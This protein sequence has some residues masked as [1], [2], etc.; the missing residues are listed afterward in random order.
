MKRLNINGT[1]VV[2]HYLPSKLT[3][4]KILTNVGSCVEPKEIWGIAHILEHMFF[5]GS[6]KRPGPLQIHAEA[7]NI[8][9]KLNAATS[10]DYTSYHITVLNEFFREGFDILADMY[11]NPI[12]PADEFTKEINPILSELRQVQDSPDTFL[13]N[14]VLNNMLGEEHYHPIIGTEKTVKSATLEYV[15]RFR[16]KYY[17]GNNVLISIVGGLDEQQVIDVVSEL[18]VAPTATDVACIK[19][20]TYNGGEVSLTKEGITEA[21]YTLT[22]PALD[23]RHPDRVKQAVMSYV[24]GGSE[25][26]MLFER[27]REELGMSCYGIYSSIHRSDPFNLLEVSCGIEPTQV[28]DLHKE[29]INQIE[30]ISS[31]KISE[32]RLNRAKTSLRTSFAAAAE[33]SGGYNNYIALPLLKGYDMGNPFEDLCLDIEKVTANDVLQQ[34]RNTFSAPSYKGILLPQS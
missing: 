9:G 18:F 4:I 12:F 13:S 22:F 29:V 8:G 17:G 1:K 11:Q 6:R 27:I 23:A 26:G 3:N 21:I 32:E 15:H 5:K 14:K 33:S 7:N 10:L 20:A 31:S 28:N 30:K 16:D 34:A 24:L 25:A 2:F 19:N